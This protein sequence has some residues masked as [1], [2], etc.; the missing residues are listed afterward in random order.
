[1]WDRRLVFPAMTV[2][3]HL[4]DGLCVCWGVGGHDLLSWLIFLSMGCLALLCAGK[5]WGVL[6]FPSSSCLHRDYALWVEVWKEKQDSGFPFPYLPGTQLVEVGEEG[7]AVWGYEAKDA[8][9]L[10]CTF[11]GCSFCNTEE[12]EQSGQKN[13]RM[14]LVNTKSSF[15][16]ILCI[17]VL[18]WTLC[19]FLSWQFLDFN[20]IFSI[21]LNKICIIN[22]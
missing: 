5:R 19:F 17:D 6:T 7:L 15:F 11:L 14:I 12:R 1:M 2:L 21:V 10:S 18:E 22:L 13:K 4:E 9:C 8:R 16:L 20:L 3:G